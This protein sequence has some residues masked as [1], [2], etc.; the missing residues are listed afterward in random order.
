MSTRQDYALHMWNSIEAENR[1]S[2]ALADAM[3]ALATD[4]ALRIQLGATAREDVERAYASEAL[5]RRN[6]DVLRALVQRVRANRSNGDAAR[7]SW[8]F[9][10]A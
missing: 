5:G 6:G 2:A 1:T 9:N 10:S 7:C 8:S 4:A 3:V